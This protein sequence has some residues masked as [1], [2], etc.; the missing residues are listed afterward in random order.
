M[1]TGTRHPRHQQEQR[2]CKHPVTQE[3]VALRDKELSGSVPSDSQDGPFPSSRLRMGGQRGLAYIIVV[4]VQTGVEGAQEPDSVWFRLRCS[5]DLSAIP[6]FALHAQRNRPKPPPGP[7]LP[8]VTP[9][10]TQPNFHPLYSPQSQKNR[11]MPLPRPRPPLATP[12]RVAP[13]CWPPSSRTRA[14]R[15]AQRPHQGHDHRW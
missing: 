6:L 5:A 2:H 10:R 12:G 9:D 4:V 1:T 8:L 3:L 13:E 15:I 7:R 11:P 14:I